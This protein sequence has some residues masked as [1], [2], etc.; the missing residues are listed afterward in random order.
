[1]AVNLHDKFAKQIQAKFVRESCVTGLLS[2]EYSWAGA[3]TVKVS[4]P[5]T[6]PMVDYTRSGVNR[7]GEPQEM[8]DTVQ[9]LTLTQD[10]S[11]ALT[12]DKGN[13]SDQSGVKSAGKMLA[14]QIKERAVPLMDGYVLDKLAHQAGHIFGASIAMDSDNICGRIADGT[15]V[16]D[17][18]EVP[19]DGRILFLSPEGFRLLKNS[20]EFMFREH[21]SMKVISNGE[22]GIFDNMRVVKVPQNRWP[23][24]LNFMIVHRDA[25]TAPVKLNDTKL[26]KDPPGLSGNLLEGR[27]YYDCF[28]FGAKANG[29]YAEVN[30]QGGA[31]TVLAAPTIST[32]GAI[33]GVSG[34]SYKFTLD[35]SDPRYSASAKIGNSAAGA[36]SGTV[37]RAYA[38]KDGAYPSQVATATLA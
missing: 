13:N 36:G 38:Y 18:A 3:K 15:T 35:G 32:A 11:F 30:T 34:A 20:S 1:M 37:V 4:T 6:V 22:A 25:A 21:L 33:S 7:Y 12:I 5:L 29:I 24:N 14:L 27:Q 2:N 26:H 31:G 9:E 16:L 8:Q 28:V 19:G 17:N 23:E 10:K